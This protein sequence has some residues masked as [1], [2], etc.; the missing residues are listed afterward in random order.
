MTFPLSAGVYEEI[1]D[2]SFLEEGAAP[3]SGG[4]VVRSKRG[5]IVPTKV[6]SADELMAL[7][8]IPSRDNPSLQC[9]FRFL[10]SANALTVRR[11]TVD[12]A[13]ATGALM[14]GTDE[15]L[16]ITAA[17]PGSW[18]NSISVKFGA[19]LGSNPSGIPDAFAVVVLDGDTQVER[20]EV[21]RDPEAQ[22]GF[23][24][25][26][27]IEEV[28]N[29]QS[30][31]IRVEDNPTIAGDYDFTSTVTLSGGTDD[32]IAPTST[33][34][35]AVWDDFL[36]DELVQAKILINAGFASADVQQKM[37]SV[38]E[39]RSDCRAILDV[40]FDVMD[41]V[42]GMIAW[43]QNFT[44]STN[45][46]AMY[47]GWIRVYDKFNSREITIPPSG[48]V[49]AA[50]VRTFNEF[51]PWDAPAGMR[52]GVLD[53]R[54]T[55]AIF[56]EEERDDLYTNGV[57]PVTTYAGVN[58]LIWGQKMMQYEASAMDRA[59]VVNNV[60]WITE[61]CKSDLKPFVFEPNTAFNRDNANY[62]L[63]SFLEG[64]QSNGGLYGFYVDTETANTP[65]VIRQNQFIVRVAI[66][67]TLTMEFIRLE[68]T[69]SPTGVELTAPAA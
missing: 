36:N 59:N 15:Q 9:A 63:S 6:T 56:T 46:A 29:N 17:N 67:P 66:Q 21:S 52:R 35:A 69:V 62:I 42:P 10:R 26:V 14:S 3:M 5:P 49:A 1:I 58:A 51:N 38:A 30:R 31:Y 39:S 20:F 19:L 55:S 25:N 11:V 23:G 57:N 4:I 53:A 33:E 60:L 24:A 48:D 34:V 40:P 13:V 37:I 18:A 28:I 16:S 41:D 68:V 27:F 12:A 8:G 61:R 22:N 45:R 32:T 64:V 47:G 2:N 65:L 7:Y 50:Y 54:G 43:R 44:N